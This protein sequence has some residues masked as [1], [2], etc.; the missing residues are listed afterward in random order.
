MNNP[1]RVNRLIQCLAT[2][3]LPT[4]LFAFK[5][6]NKL[7]LGILVYV[8]SIGIG[9]IGIVFGSLHIK[10]ILDISTISVSFSYLLPIAVMN[11]WCKDWNKTISFQRAS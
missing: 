9:I 6:I 5:R 11:K 8:V 2:I 1:K 4:G 3:F 7:R 10:M